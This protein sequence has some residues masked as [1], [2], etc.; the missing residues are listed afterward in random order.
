MACALSQM[1]DP[2]QLRN[3]YDFS[4]ILT[5]YKAQRPQKHNSCEPVAPRIDCGRSTSQRFLFAGAH[6][7]ITSLLKRIEPNISF[8]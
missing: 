8:S 2:P 6:L 3:I 4:T 5:I 7:V 1:H